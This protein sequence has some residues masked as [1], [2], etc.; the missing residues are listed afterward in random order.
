[1]TNPVFDAIV[2]AG[3]RSQADPLLQATGKL[4]KSLIE[5]AGVPMGVRVI[6]AL[7]ASACIEN[8]RLCGPSAEALATEPRLQSLVDNAVATWFEPQATPSTSAGL[9]LAHT[10]AQRPVLLT[11]ADHP[12]LRSEM[13]EYFCEASLLSGADV[14][15]GL[16]PYGLVQ[17]LF[18]DMKKTISRF[19]DGE[20]C[21][22]NL[23]GFMTERGRVMAD[24]WREVEQQ[25][26]SPLRVIKIIGWSAVV[27]YKLGII[28]LD[29]ALAML[30]KRMGVTIAAVRMPFG[31]AGV[32]VDSVSDREFVE[33][34]FAQIRAASNSAN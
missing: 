15:V 34:R 4:S 28:S 32:D 6:E 5:I 21:G 12:L 27:R 20:F 1:V 3:E 16:A 22:C 30:S 10:E 26:K 23:F 14:T 9:M 8:I 31:D 29:G 24:R 33:Q 17:P 7:G 19:S 2:L 25:R 11:T 18:P 13:I